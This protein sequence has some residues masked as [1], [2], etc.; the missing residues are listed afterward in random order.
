MKKGLVGRLL[1]HHLDSV[2]YDLADP[3]EFGPLPFLVGLK[4]GAL[5][6]RFRFE[7]LESAETRSFLLRA[8]PRDQA[9]RE[10]Y[11]EVLIVIDRVNFL[12]ASVEFR[13]GRNGR[14]TQRYRLSGLQLNP[15]FDAAA[16]VPRKIAGWEVMHPLE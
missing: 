4:A 12:P 6:R 11:N 3:K 16:F 5:E 8:I 7:Q 13:M 15:S 10:A 14:D 2:F 1:K 9:A